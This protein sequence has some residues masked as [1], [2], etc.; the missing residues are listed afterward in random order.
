MHRP[1][2]PHIDRD[3]IAMYGWLALI[4]AGIVAT[5]LGGVALTA[6]TGVTP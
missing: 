4:A 1:H 5:Y 6:C 2:L 3:V